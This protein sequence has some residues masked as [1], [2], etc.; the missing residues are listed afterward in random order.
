MN[1]FRNLYLLWNNFIPFKKEKSLENNITTY[2]DQ[3]NYLIKKK[4]SQVIS[5]KRKS[6]NEIKT[7]IC[8]GQIEAYNHVIN[9]LRSDLD[10]II[11]KESEIKQKSKEAI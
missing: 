4:R 10:E 2:K 9:L 1:F 5:R 8:E 6:N 7:H 3:L 11:N